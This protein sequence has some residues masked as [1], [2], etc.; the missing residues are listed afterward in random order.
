MPRLAHWIEDKR[1][2]LRVGAPLRIGPTATLA[3]A[4]Y[5]RREPGQIFVIVTTYGDESGTHDESPVMC[6]R[7]MSPL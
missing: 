3:L 4:I 5:H 1:E 6:S 7:A 2:L